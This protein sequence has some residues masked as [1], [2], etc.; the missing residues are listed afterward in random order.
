M[1]PDS[2]T[3]L[4]F[5]HGLHVES[6]HTDDTHRCLVLTRAAGPA[7]CFRAVLQQAVAGGPVSVAVGLYGFRKIRT[8]PVPDQESLREAI[9]GVAP[10][11][12]GRCLRVC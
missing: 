2:A 12:G 9:S 6:D 4:A 10:H 3:A 7:T 5:R 1:N 8:I 11:M